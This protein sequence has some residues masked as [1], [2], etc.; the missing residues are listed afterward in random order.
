[1]IHEHQDNKQQK[2]TKK[3]P[4]MHSSFLQ[5]SDPDDQSWVS[6]RES[7]SSRGRARFW[8]G[9]GCRCFLETSVKRAANLCSH[10]RCKYCKRIFDP[11][12]SRRKAG[13]EQLQHPTGTWSPP[14]DSSCYASW[15]TRQ[16]SQ[17]MLHVASLDKNPFNESLE[18]FSLNM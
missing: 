12:A 14:L 5:L 18:L 13:W 2:Q 7:Y 1:M 15:Y 16:H 11:Q 6:S 4:L 10:L 17:E 9:P 3:Q 8:T